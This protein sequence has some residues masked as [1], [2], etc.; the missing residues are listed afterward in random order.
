M[1]INFN[2][3]SVKSFNMISEELF[4]IICSGGI[5]IILIV[6]IWILRNISLVYRLRN[7][8]ANFEV[9]KG[10]EKDFKEK[11]NLMITKLEKNDLH[12]EGINFSCFLSDPEMQRRIFVFNNFREIEPII[13]KY[14]EVGTDE[15]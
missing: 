6:L 2:Y 9:C 13:L 11:V 12:T 8:D 15:R 10:A 4:I 14:Q 1:A 7:R 5:T 3:I